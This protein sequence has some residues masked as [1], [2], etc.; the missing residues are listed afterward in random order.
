MVV[1]SRP[2]AD[3]ATTPQLSAIVRLNF[4]LADIG[5]TPPISSTATSDIVAA[6]TF[7]DAVCMLF[8]GSVPSV[9]LLF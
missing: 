2:I 8:D 5:L 3:L 1:G 7:G 4:P 6:T 9:K